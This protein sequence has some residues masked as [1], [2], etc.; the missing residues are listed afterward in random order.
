VGWN[1]NT[2]GHDPPRHAV[3]TSPALLPPLTSMNAIADNSWLDWHCPSVFPIAKGPKTA[4][5][6]LLGLTLAAP[7]SSRHSPS[8][9]TLCSSYETRRHRRGTPSPSRVAHRRPPSAASLASSTAG[10][11]IVDSG[12][13]SLSCFECGEAREPANRFSRRPACFI[14]ASRR[15]S[16]LKMNQLLEHPLET[17]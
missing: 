16:N 14:F 17:I 1:N 11:C 12:T 10:A 2:A 9:A 15:K 7:T 6:R 3:D 5:P 4:P 13:S 8:S